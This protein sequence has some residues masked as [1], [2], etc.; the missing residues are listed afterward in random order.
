MGHRDVIRHNLNKRMNER[1]CVCFTRVTS[2]S[3]LIIMNEG[4][5]L[6]RKSEHN[7]FHG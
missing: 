6:R 1:T 4:H 7:F 3:E 5:L 2:L